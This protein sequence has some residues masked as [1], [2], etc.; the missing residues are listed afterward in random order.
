MSTRDSVQAAPFERQ[1]LLEIAARLF[2]ENGYERTGLRDI[3]KACGILP[4]SLHYRYKAK[5]DILIDMMTLA[6]ERITASIV[7][8]TATETDPLKRMRAAIQAHVDELLSGDDMTY[9]LLF[10]WRALRGD[11]AGKIIAERD[12]YERVWAAMLDALKVKG[13]IRP[14]VDIE[15]MRL[16]GL[17]AVNWVATWYK[18]TGRYSVSDIAD[19]IWSMLSRGVLDAKYHAE[20]SR[21]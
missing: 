19:A 17:G 21:L 1:R 13:F 9:V 15:V 5:E 20:A 12:R 8:A 11:A 2:R 16:I 4:G 6:I 14:D 18:P 3:A 10:E 7:E